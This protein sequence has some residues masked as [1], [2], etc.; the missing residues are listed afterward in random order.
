MSE[1]VDET[2]EHDIVVMREENGC[3][4]ALGIVTNFKMTDRYFIE[5]LQGFIDKW[6]RGEVTMTDL[7]I[8]DADEGLH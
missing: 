5:A 3:E 2:E 4:I 7:T 1:L 6:H 8:S